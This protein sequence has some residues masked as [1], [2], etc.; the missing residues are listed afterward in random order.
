MGDRYIHDGRAETVEDQ[1]AAW[2]RMQRQLV[3]FNW[4]LAAATTVGAAAIA[5]SALS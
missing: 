2:E 4:I 3:I 5:L 1:A